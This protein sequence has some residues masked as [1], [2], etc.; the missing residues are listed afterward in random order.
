MAKY[1]KRPVEVEAVQWTGGNVDDI[2]AFCTVPLLFNYDKKSVTIPTLE[3]GMTASCGDF[4]I[5]GVHGEFYPCKPDIFME[6][7]QAVD[8]QY[9]D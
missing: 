9:V 5:K 4:I 3:G 8:D 7:Y 6:T 2:A 1:R